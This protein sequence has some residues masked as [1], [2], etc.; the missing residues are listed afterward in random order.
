[1]KKTFI[2]LILF[3]LNNCSGYE[4]IFSSKNI[5][6][7]IDEIIV[8]SNDKISQKI[9]RKFNPYLNKND[10]KK[11]LNLEIKSSKTINIVGKDEKGDASVFEIVIVSN[12][13]ISSENL[14]TEEF[15]YTEKFNYNNQ[16][17]KFELEQY[18]Q[19]IETNLINKIFE[20]LLTQLRTI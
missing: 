1:M 17:N 13:K 9:K 2:F 7:Q 10:S 14:N 8:V 4:P 11:I 18:K 16:S 12:I 5:N 19:N 20:K 6:F 15:E 3:V